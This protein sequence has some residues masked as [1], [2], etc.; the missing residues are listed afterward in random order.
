M[1]LS[2]SKWKFEKF[3]CSPWKRERS[4]EDTLPD[5][6]VAVRRERATPVPR[7][8][9]LSPASLA[10][11]PKPR[12]LLPPPFAHL[13]H[14]F[15]CACIDCCSCVS[16]SGLFFLLFWQLSQGCFLFF[17]QLWFNIYIYR[18][19][20]RGRKGGNA[21]PM[22]WRR[23]LPSISWFAGHALWIWKVASG[24]RRIFQSQRLILVWFDVMQRPLPDDWHW[25]KVGEFW[26][27]RVG[28]FRM[29]L[30][31]ICRG[32]CWLR[33]CWTPRVSP[34]YDLLF[35]QIHTCAWNSPP[36][37]LAI[38]QRFSDHLENLFSRFGR[39]MT[40]PL[41]WK[42]TPHLH[43]P[44]RHWSLICMWLPWLRN[45]PVPSTRFS[46][47]GRIKGIETRGNLGYEEDINQINNQHIKSRQQRW[48]AR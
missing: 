33:P 9:V 27:M 39:E 45:P 42:P 46:P 19:R 29:S 6:T 30:H 20:E 11:R 26:E 23:P 22:R 41:L 38:L 28:F 48:M 10:H 12:L 17:F 37:M 35:G 8:P 15:D 24:I 40:W 36:E 4:A 47:H 43:G 31:G 32:C 7:W 2:N 14:L 21:P 1:L 25:L 5:A 16:L 18:E 44:W 13:L 34:C 3:S